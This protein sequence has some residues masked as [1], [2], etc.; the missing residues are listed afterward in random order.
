MLL[1]SYS[2]ICQHPN[3]A[4]NT[5]ERVAVA[6]FWMMLLRQNRWMFHIIM[7]KLHFYACHY[8]V[9]R[10]LFC[11]YHWNDPFCVFFN[12][13]SYAQLPCVLDRFFSFFFGIGTAS[14]NLIVYHTGIQTQSKWEICSG[15]YVWPWI[16]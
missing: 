16:K 2:L 6:N 3:R 12:L 9:S 4:S 8:C 5:L 1:F 7:F 11:F 14:T 10:F 15:W 13:F